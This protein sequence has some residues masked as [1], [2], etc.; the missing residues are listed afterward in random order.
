[1]YVRR[2]ALEFPDDCRVVC[3]DVGRRRIV[4]VQH[5]MQGVGR[6][7]Y[8]GTSLIRNRAPLGP[9]GSTTLK[10]LRWP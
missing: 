2:E 3:S 8:R 10:A 5:L 7:V 9:Y 6:R 1:M 4:F